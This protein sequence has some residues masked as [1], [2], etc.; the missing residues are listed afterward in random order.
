MSLE[1]C[2]N[3]HRLILHLLRNISIL[4]I[5]GCRLVTIVTVGQNIFIPSVIY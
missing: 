2:D 5:Y 4:A 1:A 3:K